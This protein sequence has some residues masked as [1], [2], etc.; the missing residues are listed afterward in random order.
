MGIKNLTQTIKKNSPESITHEN[1]YKLSGKRV[2][3]DASLILINNSL[4]GRD[5]SGIKKE[6]SQTISP[7][8]STKL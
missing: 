8:H 3:V 1:L 2:A 6:R 7:E 4:T 5:Y